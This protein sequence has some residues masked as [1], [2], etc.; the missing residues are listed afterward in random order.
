MLQQGF[1]KRSKDCAQNTN[2][3]PIYLPCAVSATAAWSVLENTLAAKEL[4]ERGIYATR[5]LAKRQIT[6]LSNTIEC[7]KFDCLQTT[8]PTCRSARC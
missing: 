7:E 4:E 6:W 8:T 1:E 2:C 5:Q 3:M